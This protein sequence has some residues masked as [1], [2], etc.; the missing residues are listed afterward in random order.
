MADLV[1]HLTQAL[2][3]FNQAREAGVRPR[4]GT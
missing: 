4:C 2:T 3:E 1:P